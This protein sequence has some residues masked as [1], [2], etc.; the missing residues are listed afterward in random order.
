MKS[1]VKL[2][3]GK[4][5]IEAVVVDDKTVD[6]LIIKKT[7]IERSANEKNSSRRIGS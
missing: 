1:L 2:V 4:K 5:A 7:L 3:R 6:R